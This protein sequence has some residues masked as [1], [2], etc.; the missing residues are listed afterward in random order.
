MENTAGLTGLGSAFSVN[1]KTSLD[2]AADATSPAVRN[3]NLRFDA[4]STFDITDLQNRAGVG[5]AVNVA[6]TNA[7]AKVAAADL[8]AMVTLYASDGYSVIQKQLLVTSTYAGND[9]LGAVFERIVSGLAQGPNHEANGW[10]ATPSYPPGTDAI[11]PTSFTHVDGA[12]ITGNA[13]NT[14]FAVVSI[15]SPNNALGGTGV[16][17]GKMYR[18]MSTVKAIG[19]PA[20]SFTKTL[21]FRLRQGT[22]ANNQPGTTYDAYAVYTQ[23]IL[24]FFEG[25][26]SPL[27][28]G[29]GG[30]NG[31]PYECIYQPPQNARLDG[32]AYN[33]TTFQLFY[34]VLDEGYNA[35]GPATGDDNWDGSSL[36]FGDTVVDAI[37]IPGLNTAIVRQWSTASDFH[38]PTPVMAGIS[39]NGW[40]AGEVALENIG[41]DSS[42]FPPGILTRGVHYDSGDTTLTWGDP[43][44]G[45]APGELAIY[46]A[47]G[48]RTAST[49]EVGD[50]QP[51]SNVAT[52]A[53]DHALLQANE[54][55]AYY[56][57]N[58]R[59]RSSNA[60]AFNNPGMRVRCGQP[61]GYN[62]GMFLT[63]DGNFGRNPGVPTVF[64]PL[65]Q[66][67]P[68]AGE[69]TVYSCWIRGIPNSKRDTINAGLNNFALYLDMNNALGTDLV[70]GEELELIGGTFGIDEVTIEQFPSYLLE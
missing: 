10:A 62:Q 31:V 30:A 46:A 5:T 49:W 41:L 2:A 68:V 42:N 28:D 11:V 70:T 61:F 16:E 66:A 18:L 29:A 6:G 21:N 35:Y 47:A 69:A 23:Q 50:P 40:V 43:A 1:L 25:L 32:I 51:A 57:V 38:T 3:K 53:L 15:M 9:I 24:D 7:E 27:N 22:S 34:D 12:Q 64:I 8:A 14:Q 39:S 20:T 17:K 52:S 55:S 26:L 65:G 36:L 63:N 13:T 56:R 58:F 4:T 33:T 44:S 37:D 67:G 59:V 60:N 19:V 54:D 48:F 45:A